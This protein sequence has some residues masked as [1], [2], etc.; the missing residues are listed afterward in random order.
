MLSLLLWML[1][2]VTTPA[3][4]LAP[5]PLPGVL[6]PQDLARVTKSPR[7]KLTRLAPALAKDGFAA[8]ARTVVRLVGEL[9][10]TRAE[11]A[12]LSAEV[13][14]IGVAKRKISKA[15]R[16]AAT[17]RKLSGDLAK[18]LAKNVVHERTLAA[19]ILAL[20]DDVDAAHQALSHVAAEDG[21]WRSREQ[22]RWSDR[23]QDFAA[24]W[25]TL[26]Q[27][28]YSFEDAL[29]PEWVQAGGQ[30]VV[31]VHAQG[32]EIFA[33][34]PRPVLEQRLD[35]FARVLAGSRFL[36]KGKIQLRPPNGW[37]YSTQGDLEAFHRSLEYLQDHPV[38]TFLGDPSENSERALRLQVVGL[39]LIDEIDAWLTENVARYFASDQRPTYLPDW[40]LVGHA[41]F[42]MLSMY[43][44]D[45]LGLYQERNRLRE[46]G[47][48][49]GPAPTGVPALEQVRERVRRAIA[50]DGFYGVR[51]LDPFNEASLHSDAALLDVATCMVEYLHQSNLAR[52]YVKAYRLAGLAAV[53]GEEADHESLLKDALS[54][55]V[56]AFESGFFHWLVPGGS[57]IAGQLD[58]FR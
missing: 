45:R 42:L 16:H 18:L 56:D 50:R 21:T 47:E 12:K 55:S 2:D 17:C 33:P 27:D 14:G 58:A 48:D 3:A 40:F 38:D 44:G 5:P 26:W 9:G 30:E 31:G 36:L 32:F 49:P 1:V 52:Q 43:S 34:L 41:R 28:G 39:D 11:L 29:A 57:S 15:A 22:Q 8:Q 51:G 53:R 46:E 10:A 23:Q 35:H 6:L 19:V 20:D 25:D 13:A 54:G 7:A 24:A 37:H 4:A